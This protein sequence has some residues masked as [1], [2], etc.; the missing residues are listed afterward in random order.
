MWLEDSLCWGGF[1]SAARVPLTPKLAKVADTYQ[2]VDTG[3]RAGREMHCA[4]KHLPRRRSL[5]DPVSW[6]PMPA[7]HWDV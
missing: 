5:P 1:S 6:M 7:K 4:G 2:L 3:L